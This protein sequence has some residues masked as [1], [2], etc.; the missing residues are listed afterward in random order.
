MARWCCFRAIELNCPRKQH[1]GGHTSATASGDRDDRWQGRRPPS[2]TGP[3][4]ATFSP[5]STSAGARPPRPVHRRHLLPNRGATPPPDERP[6]DAVGAPVYQP[7]R[8]RPPVGFRPIG[9]ACGVH[10]WVVHGCMDQAFSSL[11][12]PHGCGSSGC[13]SSPGGCRRS[14]AC[15]RTNCGTGGCRSTPSGN[16]LWTG[17]ATRS[18]TSRRPPGHCGYWRRSCDRDLPGHRRAVSAWSSARRAVGGFPWRGPG[19]CAGRCRRGEWQSPGRAV[20]VSCR[21]HPEAGGADL[22]LCPADPVRG[23]P[24]PGRLAGAAQTAA[25]S[26]RPTSARSS[27]TSPAT[28]RRNTW[29]CGAGS[30][31]SGGSRRTGA[32]CLL[33]DFLQARSPRGRQ[34]RATAQGD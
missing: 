28:P 21:G 15:R 4:S 17:S 33:I 2:R 10:R 3:S 9:A 18:A 24:A 7:G 6:A 27:R 1:P 29:P 12:T 5:W 23:R 8:T 25:T 16:G 19:R 31:P 11:S 14:P 20:Q 30:P 32:R 13:T 22:P 26:T 34:D